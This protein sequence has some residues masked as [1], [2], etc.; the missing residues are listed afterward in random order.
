MF[1]ADI[2]SFGLLIWEMIALCPPVTE[3]LA[4]DISKCTDMDP[5]M[6][7]ELLEKMSCRKRPPIPTSVDLGKYIIKIVTEIY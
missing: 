6:L 5:E 2:Y 7:D 1:L 3:E 4:D